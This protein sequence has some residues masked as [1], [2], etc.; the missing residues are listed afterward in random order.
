MRRQGAVSA[1]AGAIDKRRR[2][3]RVDQSRLGL[4]LVLPLL[5]ILHLSVSLDDYEVSS[6]YTASV[7]CVRGGT[8]RS[9]LSLFEFG[10][11]DHVSTAHHDPVRVAGSCCSGAAKPG[12]GFSIHN[13]FYY[14]TE[15]TLRHCRFVGGARG[16][17]CNCGG[18]MAAPQRHDR[19]VAGDGRFWYQLSVRH[20]MPFSRGLPPPSPTMPDQHH[21]PP[22]THYPPSML[23]TTRHL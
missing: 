11:G 10:H 20:V 23:T 8:G 12:D 19:T 14:T 16:A 9:R 7:R 18:R 4:L 2:N 3:D 5:V 13:Q 21:P 17:S 15:T 1:T 22:T 6:W